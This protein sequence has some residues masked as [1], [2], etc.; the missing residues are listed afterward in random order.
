VKCRHEY[1]A[2]IDN[3]LSLLKEVDCQYVIKPIEVFE[4]NRYKCIV[5]PYVSG[6]CLVQER[7]REEVVK[8]VVKVGLRAL[9]YMHSKGIWHRDVKVENFLISDHDSPVALILLTD[10]GLATKVSDNQKLSS[11]FVGT[12]GFAAP[13]I[14]QNNAYDSSCD[15]WSLGVTTYTL[16]SGSSPFPNS[17]ECCL[18][19]CIEK[20]AYFYPQ[21]YWKHVS[22]EAKQFIDG[23]LCVDPAERMTVSEA[24][25]HPWLTGTN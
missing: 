13:E 17:P 9:D 18:R 4:W 2:H 22:P 25:N 1:A 16:L 23:M 21:R 6:G 5:M 3:E 11:D 14:I 10:L 12:L 24:L 7:Y 15:I 8:A 19:R 20:G